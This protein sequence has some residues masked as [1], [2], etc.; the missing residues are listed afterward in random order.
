MRPMPGITQ[1]PLGSSINWAHPTA[2]GLKVAMP[3]ASGAG[4]RVV[5][6]ADSRTSSLLVGTGIKWTGGRSGN[7]LAF[8]GSSQSLAIPIDLS[9]TAR[10]TV[11]FWMKWTTNGND[12]RLALEFTSNF[13]SFT[14]GFNVDVN[15]SAFSNTFGLSVK[16]DV[17]YN[18]YYYT[19][20]SAG[21]WHNWTCI[22]SKSGP[23]INQGVGIWLDGVYVNPLGQTA[24]SI[25]TNNF[26]NDTLYV[27]S[28]G[29]ASLFGIG[30]MENLMVWDRV[31]RQDEAQM[32]YNEPY[33]MYYW[34]R[35][36][37]S[38][39]TVLPSLFPPFPSRPTTLQAM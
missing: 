28:R 27:M 34:G 10:C 19:Q 36:Q 9:M 14:T 24:S 5:N 31:I 18:N 22:F 21:V 3:F 33:G 23:A 35:Q 15:Y 20:P 16:G 39:A 30:S 29:G 2:R 7:A 8:A 11:S 1:P 26:G 25:N 13:N 38:V 37:Q 4:T 6:L 12:D 32:L 17:G